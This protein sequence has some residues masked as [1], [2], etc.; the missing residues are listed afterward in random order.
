MHSYSRYIYQ[1]L[2]RYVPAKD[3]FMYA[4]FYKL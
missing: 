4:Y 2:L 1:L 3:K